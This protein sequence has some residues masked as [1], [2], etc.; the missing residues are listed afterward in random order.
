MK[1][2]M[3]RTDKDKNAYKYIFRAFGIAY[4][5]LM[6]EKC[7]NEDIE[8]EITIRDNVDTLI[9]FSIT[10]RYMLF[11]DNKIDLDNNTT[12]F[13]MDKI[14]DCYLRRERIEENR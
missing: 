9:V 11:D 10:D 2:R 3:R 13:I 5:V 4:E 6:E 12:K 14:R 1:M 8:Y 7:G